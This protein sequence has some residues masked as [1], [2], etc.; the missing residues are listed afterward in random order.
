MVA[1][2]TRPGAGGRGVRTGTGALEEVA[3]GAAPGGGGKGAMPT[4]F[5]SLAAAAAA[6]EAYFSVSPGAR[7]GSGAGFMLLFAA[8]ELPL[9]ALLVVLWSVARTGSGDFVCIEGLR[10]ETAG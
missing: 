7:V 3:A 4:P 10:A 2:V 9:A 6:A 5:L 8:C 1:A